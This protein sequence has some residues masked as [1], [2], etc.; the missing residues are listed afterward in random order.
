M[1]PPQLR[2]RPRDEENNA[3]SIAQCSREIN[4]NLP[5][6]VAKTDQKAV[7]P[8]GSIPCVL[9]APKRKNSER[10]IRMA[11]LSVGPPRHPWSLAFLIPSTDGTWRHD[12]Q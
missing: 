6:A 11:A 2:V 10:R 8:E 7:S 4:A 5:K 3:F 9:I 1:E 12:F